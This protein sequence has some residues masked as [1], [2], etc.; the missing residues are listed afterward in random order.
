MSLCPAQRAFFAAL[1]TLVC[2]TAFFA[3]NTKAQAIQPKQP[4]GQTAVVIDERLSILRFEPSLS[5]VIFQRIS[6]GREVKVL[7]A[8]KVDGV[9]F[10][11]V[12]VP[13]N[14]RAWIQSEA[15]VSTVRKGDD[16]RLF[17]LIKASDGMDKIER[18]RIFLEVFYNSPH[19]PATLLIFGDAAND[20]AE[21]LSHDIQRKFD[22]KEVVASGAPA[23][24]FYWN[25]KELDKFR[26]QGMNFAFDMDQKKFRYD[27]AE[28]REIVRRFP[29][30]AEAEEARKRLG[31]LQERAVQK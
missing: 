24:S 8:K 20:T 5:A 23:H 4:K 26:R 3:S 11:R 16:E 30:S 12:F 25:F 1:L 22:E 18:A 10:Y 17:N 14:T 6:H 21:K 9:V 2:F 15:V 19:R 28:W 7:G 13:P 27:G 29:N 31:L